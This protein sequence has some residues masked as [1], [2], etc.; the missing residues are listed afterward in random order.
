[1]KTTTQRR[2]TRPKRPRVIIARNTLER[3]TASLDAHSLTCL[4]WAGHQIAALHG[5]QP[6]PPVLIRRA[7]DVYVSQ[8]RQLDPEDRG[9]FRRLEEA[10]KGQGGAI[11][12]TEARAR[13]E[14]AGG[15]PVPF[16]EVRYSAEKLKEQRELLAA[17]EKHMEGFK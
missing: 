12:L 13:L 15:R 5:L 2:P 17:L 9:E 14:A 8:L 16:E 11:T 7:L 10:A 1:M 3:P 6:Q 4:E